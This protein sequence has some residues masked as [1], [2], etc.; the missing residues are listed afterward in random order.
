MC[1]FSLLLVGKYAKLALSL[2][3]DAWMHAY[4]R[5]HTGQV[6]KCAVRNSTN[7]ALLHTM[8]ASHR[9]CFPQCLIMSRTQPPLSSMHTPVPMHTHTHSHSCSPLTFPFHQ[10]AS[11]LDGSYGHPFVCVW[12]TRDV[13]GVISR[14]DFP[15]EEGESSR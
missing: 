14:I 8:R 1:F 4:M 6:A 13:L 11:A 10:I 12:D 2:C 3:M 5:I 7:E 15:D 9:L